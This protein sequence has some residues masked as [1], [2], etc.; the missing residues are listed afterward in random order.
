MALDLTDDYEIFDGVETVTHLTTGGS[1]DSV[2]YAL[3]QP[4]MI[5]DASTGN[6]IS[7][8]TRTTWQLPAAEMANAPAPGH[9]IT[10]TSGV[11]WIVETAE[12]LQL[13]GKWECV[14]VIVPTVG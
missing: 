4:Y 1:S 5:Q 6:W 11:A 8:S 7:D 3:R 12:L 2:P 14:C 13:V 9:K 10:Q